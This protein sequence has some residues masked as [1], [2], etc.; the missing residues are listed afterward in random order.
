MSLTDS[1]GD[2]SRFPSAKH[3]AAWAEGVPTIYESAGK[4]RR[5]G[6]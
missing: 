5:V 6:R 4:C 1:D 3:L 2:M